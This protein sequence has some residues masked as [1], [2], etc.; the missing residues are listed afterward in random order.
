MAD[1]GADAAADALLLDVPRGD[2]RRV[3]AYLL[4]PSHLQYSAIMDVLDDAA[5]DLTLTQVCEGLRARG[6]EMSDAAVAG[7]LG[8]LHRQ[9][10]AVRP[11]PGNDF[12]RIEDLNA[13]R[14]RYS[15]TADGRLVHRFWRRMREEGTGRHEIPLTS[16]QTIVSALHRLA[17]EHLSPQET[18][19]QVEALFLGHDALDRSMEGNA[20]HLAGLANRFNLD[21]EEAIE[22]KRLLVAYATHVAAQVQEAVSRAFDLLTELRPRFGELA[23]TAASQ[24]R[25]AA[26]VSKGY[27]VAARGASEEHWVQLLEW[28]RPVEGRAARFTRGLVL[29]IRP[30]HL[31]L[32][33]LQGGS[34]TSV[35]SRAI[36]LAKVCEDREW[37]GQVTAA[38]LGDHGWMK[39]S[40][41]SE[42]G[43]GASWHDGPVVDIPSLERAAARSGARS[44]PVARARS[45]SAA[46]ELLEQVERE[47]ALARASAIAEVL[48]SKGPLSPDAGR[49]AL[50]AVTAALSSPGRDGVRSGSDR[51]RRLVC[52]VNTSEGVGRVTSEGW[53]ALLP[54]R[55]VAFHY[56]GAAAKGGSGAGSGGGA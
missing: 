50:E 2:L 55:R 49:V 30:L 47:Q 36:R 31:N 14:W 33:R 25:A 8:R 6:L 12:A 20:D 16:L 27:L 5:G 3:L 19:Q 32:R 9:F 23:G 29:A 24:S 54:G 37:G 22:L 13:T 42:D 18:A 17:H 41:W 48:T 53:S 43:D 1:P 28:C 44:G 45:R 21:R 15:T 51:S 40:G 38:A 4:S 26:L 35:R 10:E 46:Q 52:A 56:G 11:D 34:H 39:L 7:R